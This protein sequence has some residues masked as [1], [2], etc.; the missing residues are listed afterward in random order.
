[1]ASAGSPAQ[2]PARVRHHCYACGRRSA[3]RNEKRLTRGRVRASRS[4]VA[5]RAGFEPARDR[6]APRRFRGAP[7]RPLS[8][9]SATRYYTAD[10]H[11]VVL[12]CSVRLFQGERHESL[13]VGHLGHPTLRARRP[14]TEERWSRRPAGY[15]RLRGGAWYQLRKSTLARA[16]RTVG[17]PPRALHS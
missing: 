8:H 10:R 11:V 15:R 3:E 4:L 16:T 17:R 14:R 5:E 7:I 1:M 13:V 9:L 2:G 6:K 12:Q